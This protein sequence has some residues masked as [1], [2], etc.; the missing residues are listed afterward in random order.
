VIQIFR[1]KGILCESNNQAV[2]ITQ[3]LGQ[4]AELSLKA[5]I[6]AVEDQGRKIG[7][8][9]E[10]RGHDIID[11]ARTL[12][13]QSCILNRAE[14][15]TANHQAV[16]SLEIPDRHKK[17]FLKNRQELRDWHSF[18]LHLKSMSQ[19]Y[20]K[21]VTNGDKYGSRYPP[22]NDFA[23]DYSPTIITVGIRFLIDEISPQ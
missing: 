21:E 9:S 7:A 19:V 2:G 13:E 17:L 5:H 1:Q 15:Y 22:K 3:L 8:A 10:K 14:E 23:R 11:L 4:A 18:A 12:Q 20:Y 6:L 16:L